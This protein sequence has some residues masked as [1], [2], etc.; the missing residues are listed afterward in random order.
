MAERANVLLRMADRIEA[1]L[2][3]LAIA[4]SW[5]NGKPCRETLAA[6]IPLAVDHL[7]DMAPPAAPA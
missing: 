7:R 3:Q 4:E 1:N 2:E 6:D 5:E